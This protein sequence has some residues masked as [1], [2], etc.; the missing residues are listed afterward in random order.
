MGIV[1]VTPDSFSD[2]GRYLEVERAVE[3][4]LR[5]VRE[6]ADI[7]D[8]GGEST[9]PGAVAV[10][11]AEELQR[12]LPVIRELANCQ[13]VPISIDTQKPEVARRA[14]EAGAVLVND[15]AANR[16]EGA[17]WKV[18]AETGA[19]YVAMHM[20]GTP[21]TMQNDP[22]YEDVVGEI[23]EFFRERL[24]T[25]AAFGVGREQVALDPG[26]GFGKTL[27]QNVELLSHLKDF[28]RFDRPVVLGVSRK[29]FLGGLTGAGVQE[30]MPAG[31]ACSVWGAL[32]GVRIVR[33]HDVGPTVQ[34]LRVTA[35]ISARA[36]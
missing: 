15:I 22:R 5:L 4:A 10:D 19:G 34:A 23:G 36:T 16:V 33:T 20:R 11:E 12:V 2:G 31:L 18:V 24:E 13:D 3:H 27:E 6:G 17:M 1:N 9:R 30:R 32:C 26:V 28:M 29:S 7:L 8:I 35:A 21:A 25:L 14:I